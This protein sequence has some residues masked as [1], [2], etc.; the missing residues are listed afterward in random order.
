[1]GVLSGEMVLKSIKYREK[2]YQ[3][4]RG[5]VARLKI[6]YWILDIGNYLLIFKYFK[7]K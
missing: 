5:E 4:S 2:K 7:L 3:V 1:L 6:A